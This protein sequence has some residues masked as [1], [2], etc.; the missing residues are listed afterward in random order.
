MGS[1]AYSL[2]WVMQDLYHQLYEHFR[3]LCWFGASAG[4]G[5]R[6][7]DAVFGRDFDSIAAAKTLS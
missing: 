6:S 1:M 3:A 5:H 2:L 7:S 4:I